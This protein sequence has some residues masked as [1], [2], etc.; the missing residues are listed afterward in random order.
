MP[1]DQTK[2]DEMIEKLYE[3][4]RAE[5]EEVNNIGRVIDN[6]NSI[7]NEEEVDRR[8]NKK[9]ATADRQKIYNDNMA[10]ATAILGQ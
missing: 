9:F 10:E 3:K 7:Q 4:A 5:K 6:L 1:V 2:L 8:T